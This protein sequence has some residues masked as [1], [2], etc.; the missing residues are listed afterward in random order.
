M[1]AVI[2]RVPG[3][4]Q[5]TNII[6]AGG[7]KLS[8]AQQA[9]YQGF[10][11]WLLAPDSP[12]FVI[13][14][15][16]GTGKSTLV[17]TIIEQLPKL[18]KMIKLVDPK[19]PDLGLEL[20]ATT[21]KA[22]ENFSQITGIS[23]GTIHSFL[24]LSVRTNYDTGETVLMPKRAGEMKHNLLI[25]IDEASYIDRIL[26]N[27]IFKLI[28][29]ASCKVCFIGDPAQLLAVK[30]MSPPVFDARFPTVELK[31]IVRQASGNPI[32]ELSTS[33]RHSVETGTWFNFKPDGQV[34]QH[35]P[36]DHFEARIV[37]EMARPDWK[38]NDSKVLAF[39]NKAVIAY[40]HAIRDCVKG[41]PH[42]QP[43]DYAVNN[44]YIMDG[45]TKIA[46]DQ[47][48]QITAISDEF[49]QYGVLGRTYTV[50]GRYNFFMPSSL[51]AW[52]AAIKGWKA[53][54]DTFMLEKVDRE[55]ID[56][57]AAYA[58]TINKSQGS[59]YGRVYIDLDDV[60][61][62]PNANQMARMLYVGI[63]RAQHQVFLTG[64]I[65]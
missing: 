61:R 18:Q 16:S 28:D 65:C 62:C 27:W 24:G 8:N 40:N 26:L 39:T 35:L 58:Q 50:D 33:F 31:D 57:R 9:A 23:C 1:S 4:S 47:M 5:D 25:F 34:I 37:E 44:H 2:D 64:D 51:E 56:L 20:T 49:E 53:L 45:K 30:S 7:L 55:W 11:Q 46:T 3:S 41:N 63:S 22:A 21:N 43:G 15:Y 12:V 52:R 42:F 36:R 59:T 32:I 19:A 6:G 54:N 14:G 38:Y 10:V 60:K 48:V 29:V 17:K 13:K